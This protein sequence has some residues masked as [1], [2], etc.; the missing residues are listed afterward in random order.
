MSR[1]VVFAKVQAA[2]AD[3]ERSSQPPE[4]DKPE[5]QL[6]SPANTP[7]PENQLLTPANTSE[8][9]NQTLASS[10]ASDL[11]KLFT[12]RLIDYKATVAH[13]D[14][15]EEIAALVLWFLQKRKVTSVVVPPGLDKAWISAAETAGIQI[16]AD[17]PPLTKAVLDE[18][19]AVITAAAVAIA[20]TGTIVLDHRPNQGRR[21][22]SLLPDTHICIVQEQ[23]IRATV[24]EA[25]ACLAPSA[26]ERRPMTWIS[27]PS[28]TVD[29]E[30]IRVEGVHGPRNLFVIIQSQK[31]GDAG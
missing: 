31:E 19:G 29:I 18:T 21:I 9:E 11:V 2:L 17:D 14:S 13:A 4:P 5:N 7:E 12:S 20:E 25:I 22:I 1:Q 30:L 27:G 6:F 28:A 24:P 10:K 15:A 23:Q 3:I 8:P 16:T 26:Q